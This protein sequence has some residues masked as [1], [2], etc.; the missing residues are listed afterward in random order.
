MMA[1]NMAVVDTKIKDRHLV[2]SRVNSKLKFRKGHY[3][4]ESHDVNRLQ[5]ENL[6]DVFLEQLNSK[7]ES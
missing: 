4:L 5:D 2:M 7:L 1:V 6:S 3:L